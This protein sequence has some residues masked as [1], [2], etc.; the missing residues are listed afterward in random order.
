MSL[1]LKSTNDDLENAVSYARDCGIAIICSTADE[2]QN[3]D[4]VWP[5]AYE[6][7]TLSIAACNQYGSLAKYGSDQAR[8]WFQGEKIVTDVQFAEDSPVTVSG[9]S[10]A[11]AVAAGVASLIVACHRIASPSQEQA[12]RE[13][14]SISAPEIVKHWFQKMMEGH[15]ESKYVKPWVVFGVEERGDGDEDWLFDV[16]GATL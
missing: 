5:A 16:F 7:K 8:Y 10:V 6:N 12:L 2:G 1:A 9:S 14:T 3:V 15:G 4:R 11:T 13:D